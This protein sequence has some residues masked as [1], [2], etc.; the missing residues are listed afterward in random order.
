MV[1]N[2]LLEH[3]KSSKQITRKH[4]TNIM[5]NKISSTKTNKSTKTIKETKNPVDDSLKAIREVFRRK[6]GVLD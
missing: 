6:V 3:L 2:K 4:K 5:S 1:Y